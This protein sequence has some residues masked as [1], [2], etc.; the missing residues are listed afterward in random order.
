MGVFDEKIK[1]QARLDDE[2]F[3]DAYQKMAG[4]V[5]GQM[6]FAF[7]ESDRLSVINAI[8]EIS[9]YL[10]TTIPY[11]SYPDLTVGW[12]LEEYF[13]PQGIMWRNVELKENW[14][15]NADGAMLGVLEDQRAVALLPGKSGRYVYRDP[16]T[17]K[18]VRITKKNAGIIREDAIL[19]YRALPLRPINMQDIRK[20]VMDSVPLRD[21]LTLILAGITVML[22]G[23]VTPHMTRILFSHVAEG[24]DLNLLRVIFLVLLLVTAATFVV[25]CIRQLTLSR[26]TGR[27]S[28]PL[29]AAFM[30]RMLTAPTGE[31]KYFSAGD[32]GSRIGAMR[33]DLKS[34][35]NM[36]L[37]TFLSALLSLVSFIPMFVYAPWPAAVA[38]LVTI[39]LADMYLVVIRKQADLSADRMAA[40]AEESGM[41]YR[42]IGGIQKI[43][44]SGSEIRAFSVWARVY[45]RA[46]QL[47]YNPPG[48]LKIYSILTAPIMLAG[49]ILMYFVAAKTGVSEADFYAFLSSY[50]LLSGALTSIGSSLGKFAGSLPV[51]RN[52][53][54][55]MDFDPE[56][57]ETKEVVHALR[58]NIS[59]RNV[60]FRYSEHSRT[61]LENLNMEIRQGEYVALVGKSGCGKS[62]ILRLLLGFE[63]PGHGEIL[64]DGRN[65]K[66]L[67]LTSLRRNIGT[68]LQKGEIFKGTIFSN[69]SISHPSLTMEEAWKAAEIAGIANDIRRMPLQMNTPLA[70]GGKGVS[71]GQKQ[72]LM[73]ARAIVSKPS[74][75]FF[76]EATSALDNITQKAVSDALGEMHCTR[77]VIAHRLSTI[78][79]CDRILCMDGGRIV[80]EGSYDE[81]IAKNGLFAELVRRQLL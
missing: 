10:H 59:V 8:E 36:F 9:A 17:G 75:L 24:N 35:L 7:F 81:L 40:Q 80:E 72:R 48:I 66:S 15:E 47:L 18:K 2:M 34:L 21:V 26:I 3:V 14:Y 5:T 63:R 53:K 30:M 64:Y 55:L 38:L 43:M 39:I 62:T 11:S 67:D 49:S 32:L 12:Y 79:N 4:V 23:L 78:R 16:D 71:G 1:Q 51:F 60:T 6:D 58:G 42:L 57:N 20:F 33:N 68:V 44:L 74:I 52:L 65:L 27:I 46:I 73:I 41:T 50:A 45:R 25:T 56:V 76:D 13:R 54:P 28:F 70:D 61:I 31:L 29:Q 69:I 19:F 77:L 37:S 22:L